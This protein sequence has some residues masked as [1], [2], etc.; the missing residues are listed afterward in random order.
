MSDPFA[1]AP[2]DAELEVVTGDPWL[3]PTP[4]P[5]ATPKVATGE[6]KVVLT[7]KGGTGFD[8]PWIV[9]HAADLADAYSQV[10]GDSA[11]LLSDLM[12]RVQTAGQHFSSQGKSGAAPRQAPPA[13]AASAPPGSPAAPGPDWTFRSG[14]TKSGPKAGQPWKGWMPPRG[15]DE[16]PIF[17]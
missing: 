9:I 7:F 2:L 3:E 15:S 11:V 17:F 10:S 1:A 4:A 14:I 8:A 5:V 16:K 12:E 6:G 13:E